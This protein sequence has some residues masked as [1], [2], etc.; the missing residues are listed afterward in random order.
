M[1]PSRRVQ[2]AQQC[3]ASLLVALLWAPAALPGLESP[4]RSHSYSH[5]EDQTAQKPMGP[6]RR[7]LHALNRL[8]FGP[9]PGDVERVEAMGVEKWIDRQMEPEKL[10]DSALEARLAPLRTL[11]MDARAMIEAFPPPPVIKAI[12]E[13]RLPMPSDPEKRAIYESQLALYR[14]RQQKKQEGA[15]SADSKDNDAAGTAAGA[16][17]QKVPSPATRELRRQARQQA[18]ALVGLA[19]DLR[20]QAILKMEPT[21]RMMLARALSPEMKD[22]MQEGMS[23]EQ[24]EQLQAM[25]G[26]QQVIT[27]ELVQAKLLRAIYS[28]RQLQVVMDDFWFN[29]FNVY[30][31]K[32]AD[33]YFTTSYERD[34]IRKH[35]MGKFKDLLMATA[36]H[37]AMLFYLDNFQS[38][39]PNS[40]AARN[41]QGGRG[42]RRQSGIGRGRRT[43][44]GG[45]FNPDPTPAANPD[46]SNMPS[47][48]PKRGLNE[49]YARELMELHTLGVD[50]G[51]TQQD[52]I[53]VAKVFTGWTMRQP[54]LGGGFEFNDR[55]HEPGD[56]TV[57]GHKIHSG[58]MDEG[59]KVLELLARNPST[60]RFISR[61][62]AMR[63]V[64]DDPPP[65]LV[66]RMSATFLKSDGDIRQVLRALFKSP[67]FWAPE[68]Y[69]AKVKTPLEFVVSAVRVTGAD[70]SNALPLGQAL[71]RMGM[72]PYQMQPPTGY[73][74]KAE[75]WVNSAALLNRMNFALTLG[76]GHMRGLTL[77]GDVVAAGAS[78]TTAS[79]PTASLPTEPDAALDAIA[80][81]LLAGD[82]SPQTRETIRKQMQSGAGSAEVRPVSSEQVSS[83]R[84]SYGRGKRMDAGL[85]AGL[86]LGSPEFQRR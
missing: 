84:A 85:I 4:S 65:A 83:D 27:G 15:D 86:L 80:Q 56:K 77:N 59:K 3:I 5:P 39:G 81:A 46:G 72:A 48:K 21:E 6:S 42:N 58:G 73:S 55:L 57:L 53:E 60:A 28:E 30:L 54:R 50:G 32:G 9:R 16:D 12:A 19:P 74:M 45:V 17:A 31:Q 61:K 69:R 66:E 11:K 34:A 24:R 67:E 41:G 18:D 79:L 36:E 62:L 29:H 76:S 43:G 22:A 68:A 20:M 25:A 8:A 64:A 63:F 71:Q 7:A 47:P 1:F 38:V 37:P 52:I 40:D 23:F 33:H 82:M 49:N 78:R 14:A 10:D 51:Y 44:R 26:P 35:S 75:T 2:R 13:G 70:V